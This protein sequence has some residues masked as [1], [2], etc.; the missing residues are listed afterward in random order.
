MLLGTAS[1]VHE[2]PTF[3]WTIQSMSQDDHNC[4]PCKHELL[5]ENCTLSL[6]ES[7]GLLKDTDDYAVHQIFIGY[8]YLVLLKPVRHPSTAVCEQRVVV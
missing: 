7:V 5:F 1:K 3:N 6:I 8:P 2:D 4:G